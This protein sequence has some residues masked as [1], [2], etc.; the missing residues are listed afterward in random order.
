[1]WV[2]C[3]QARREEGGR[4]KLPRAPR[5]FGGFAVA[6][7]YKVHQNVPFLKE[8]NQKIFPEGPRKNVSSGP[9]VA[10]DGFVVSVRQSLMGE[11]SAQALLDL[12]TLDDD[13][14]FNAGVTFAVIPPGKRYRRLK[15]ASGGEKTMA[16]LALLFAMQS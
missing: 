5:R 14:P 7:K 11:P 16:V 1:V 12:D 3:V 13:E 9:A 2:N 6:Q 8:K 4:G 15:D 10:L